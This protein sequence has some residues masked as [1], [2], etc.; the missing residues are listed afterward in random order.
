M[1][2]NTRYNEIYETVKKILIETLGTKE[3]KIS[4][5]TNF[6]NDLGADSLDTLEII[7]TIEEKFNIYCPDNDVANIKTVKDL[8]EYIQKKE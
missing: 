5:K 6:T 4:E 8:V 1:I 2:E 7:M 3:N